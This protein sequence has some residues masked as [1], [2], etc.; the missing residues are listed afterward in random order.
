DTSQTSFI[1]GSV[2]VGA[3]PNSTALD[4]IFANLKLAP[5][6][7]VHGLAD[8]DTHKDIEAAAKKTK[9]DLH[10]YLPAREDKAKFKALVFDATGIKNTAEL[11]AVWAFFHPVIR[12]L[13]KCA[14]IVVIGRTP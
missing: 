10:G 6:A 5:A 1:N 13:N 9:Q 11:N 14:R 3:A 2:L 4:S 12:K 8:A 7:D